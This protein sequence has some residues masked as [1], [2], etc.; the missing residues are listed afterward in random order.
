MAV[1]ESIFLSAHEAHGQQSVQRCD[2]CGHDL[3][4]RDAS[5][6]CPKC[7][8]L[9]AIIHRA[10]LDVM[11]APLEPKAVQHAFVQHCCAMPMGH[12]SGV[13]RFESLVMPTAGDA[14][15]SHPEGNTP[16]M[17]RPRVST[18]AG[19]E[20]LLLKHEGYNPTGSFKDRGMTVGTTQAVRTGATAVACASTGNTSASLASYA[21]QAG[22]PGLVFVPAGKVA[23]GK[24]AQTLAYGAKT[25]LV[26]GDF[27]AC[28]RL[29]QDASREL[30]IYLL[31]SIN[32]WRVEGQKTIVFEILQQLGWDAP[33]FIVLPAGNLGNTAAFGKALREAK[34][35]GLIAKVPRLVSVQAAGAAPFAKGFREDFAQRY[36]VQ[37]E[38]IATAIRIGDPASWD[39]AVR[40]I[41]ETNGMVLS[42][43]D[44]EIV[45]AKVQIDAAGVGCE[46]A[47][48]A[49]VAG[50]KQLVRDGVIRAGDRV[51]A[52]LTGHVLK[53]PGML[54]E[55]H[56]Q[57][58][59]FAQANRPVEID[60]SV[61][62]VER[63][64]AES[65]V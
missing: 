55:L 52:V 33:D 65:R 37:A 29:V 53:D 35:L 42:V 11:G 36:T 39:R 58:A 23:L 48:A 1:N 38:T 18:W 30:G 61:A 12:P 9:L 60:A 7:G 64:I 63:V 8:G 22:I 14:I 16:L 20:G 17:E 32:P 6:A 31:N 5:P 59:D 43:T 21:A 25:L 46:P 15:T 4:E 47:S 40:A 51:V 56:Q 41:R 19:C 49:S 34:A 62:A 3:D 28:L 27:D 24:M 57:R 10:P 44:D 50:V 2:D 26:K 13:W 54:V 45:D